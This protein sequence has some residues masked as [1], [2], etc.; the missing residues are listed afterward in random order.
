MPEPLAPWGPTQTTFA[1]LLL[2]NSKGRDA[3]AGKTRKEFISV[4]TL[5]WR[6]QDCLPSAKNTSGLYKENV[7]QRLV[8][9]CSEIVKVIVIHG[10]GLAGSGQFLL[11]GVGRMA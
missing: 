5:D 3:S 1:C 2:T 8:G 9:T 11:V 7:R 10:W 6:L 4:E